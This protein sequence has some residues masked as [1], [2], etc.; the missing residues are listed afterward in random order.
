MKNAGST[1]L[2]HRRV[3]RTSRDTARVFWGGVIL[4]RSFAKQLG[5]AAIKHKDNSLG[6][7]MLFVLGVKSG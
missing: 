1:E 4:F 2:S 6:D 7:K 3:F 5:A